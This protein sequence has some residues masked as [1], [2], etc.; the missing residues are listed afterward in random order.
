M[1]T[2]CVDRLAVARPVLRRAGGG[3]AQLAASLRAGP[4]VR[5]RGPQFG[6]GSLGA[7]AGRRGAGRERRGAPRSP[8]AVWC[9][10]RVR[11]WRS[12]FGCGC[13]RWWWRCTGSRGWCRCP[14]DL[15]RAR[16]A[17]AELARVREH[18]GATRNRLRRGAQRAAPRRR[19]SAGWPWAGVLFDLRLP[20]AGLQ[21][22]RPLGARGHARAER[23][24][25]RPAFVK[26]FVSPQ[27]HFALLAIAATALVLLEPLRAALSA[28]LFCEA[29][30]ARGGAGLR[31]LVRRALAQARRPG[32]S[33]LLGLGLLMGL[34]ASPLELQAQAPEPSAADEP[35]AATEEEPS[36]VTEEEESCDA[37]C[38]ARAPATKRSP[39]ASAA[40][41]STA[42]LRSSPT[43]AGRSTM[44]AA[45]ASPTGSPAYFTTG[46]RA[47]RN[48]RPTS[49]P[50]AGARASCP[51]PIP[52]VLAALLL[53]AALSRLLFGNAPRGPRAAPPAPRPHAPDPFE[54]SPEEHLAAALAQFALEP[55]ERCAPCTLP[56][57]WVY[58][59]ATCW[60]SRLSAATAS[61][62][63]SS[64]RA[65]SAAPS[66]S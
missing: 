40:C 58:R 45:A 27:N 65:A 41:S 43:S 54:R 18:A 53:L 61:T 15:R 12:T 55:R 9:C 24:R 49:A 5:V 38:Q 22:G 19:A 20:R 39:H 7:P 3:R 30:L 13:G 62:C 64:K 50:W 28:V 66:P 59:G 34:L 31:A 32:Q 11:G 52:S 60:S 2:R 56:P 63:T 8:R 16:R 6:A 48:R 23:T 26:A 17:G 33:V 10:A 44:W 47:P 1:G 46:S 42:S 29:E 51:A 37:P 36:A 4:G 35:R 57:W 14:V 25:T 21:P